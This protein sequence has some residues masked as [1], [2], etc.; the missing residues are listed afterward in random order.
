M[1]M[2]IIRLPLI[3]LTFT[4]N[5]IVF[6]HICGQK[7]ATLQSNLIICYGLV[8]TLVFPQTKN[9]ATLGGHVVSSGRKF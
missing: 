6:G 9:S 3:R 5:A 2:Q 7:F 1:C 8:E 4:A